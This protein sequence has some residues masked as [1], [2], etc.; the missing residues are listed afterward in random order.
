MG[1]VAMPCSPQLRRHDLELRAS[2]AA[3]ALCV[4]GEELLDELPDGVPAMTLAEVA[5]TL[6][7]DRAAGD[8]RGDRGDGRRGSRR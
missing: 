2:A 8:A 5:A 7:E 4:A 3:P 6:D 1:A